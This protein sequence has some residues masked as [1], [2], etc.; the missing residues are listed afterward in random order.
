VAD[1]IEE[2]CSLTLVFDSTFVLALLEAVGTDVL[3]VDGAALA[4]GVGHVLHL[5]VLAWLAKGI[6]PSE[7]ITVPVVVHVGSLVSVNI[8]WHV[9]VSSLVSLV[10]TWLARLESVILRESIWC[11]WEPLWIVIEWRLASTGCVLHTVW[12]LI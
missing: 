7:T 8:W 12:R 4:H 1:T 2:L 5:A 11:V 9:E 6:L 10:E 3:P